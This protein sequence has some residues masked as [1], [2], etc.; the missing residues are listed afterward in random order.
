MIRFRGSEEKHCRHQLYF[1]G[2]VSPIIDTRTDKVAF[3]SYYNYNLYVSKHIIPAIGHLSLTQVRPAHIEQLLSEKQNLSYSSQ[4]HILIALKGIFKT[5]VK[6]GFC[7]RN[8]TEDIT[9]KQKPSNPPEVFTTAEISEILTA[10]KTHRYGIYVQALLY[11]GLRMGEL[12]ALQWGD[13]DTTNGL[14]H[15]RHAIAKSAT[16]WNMKETKTGRARHIGITNTFKD[17]LNAQAKASLFILPGENGD[18]LRPNQFG[19]RYKQF[20]KE[21]GLAYLSPHKCRHTYATHLIKGGADLRSVQTLLGHAQIGT[22]EIYTHVDADMLKASVT[23]LQ[24]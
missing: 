18:F 6:N 22:T 10:A 14:I 24:F 8:P 20:F 1:F 21:T 12:L 9:T 7:A 5:A 2:E 16:G 23:K 19:F 17:I 11:S 3:E 15:V 4:H 13:I